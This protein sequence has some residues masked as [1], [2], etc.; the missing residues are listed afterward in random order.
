MQKDGLLELCH[1]QVA[2]MAKRLEELEKKC[3]KQAKKIVEME[4]QEVMELVGKNDQD[5]SIRYV[6]LIFKII[7]Q[8]KSSSKT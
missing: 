2:K 6:S 7:V 3:K 8:H 5:T 4:T 1:S